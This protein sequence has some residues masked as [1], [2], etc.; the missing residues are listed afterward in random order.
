MMT[1]LSAV[2]PD[3]HLAGDVV[4]ATIVAFSK[5]TDHQKGK[6]RDRTATTAM[7]TVVKDLASIT[8]TVNLLKVDVAVLL[9]RDKRGRHG[10]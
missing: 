8:E 6:R 3:A 10:D 9:D 2:V 5:W 1:Q 4:L 7:A